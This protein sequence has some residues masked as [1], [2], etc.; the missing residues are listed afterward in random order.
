MRA[1]REFERLADRVESGGPDT[2][3]A[4]DDAAARLRTR[5]RALRAR[6]ELTPMTA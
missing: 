3:D 6:L 1:A 5:A 4:G 2:S